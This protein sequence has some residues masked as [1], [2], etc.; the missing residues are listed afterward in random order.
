MCFCGEPILDSCC[1]SVTSETVLSGEVFIFVEY[2]R[3]RCSHIAPPPLAFP[4]LVRG[5]GNE[6]WLYPVDA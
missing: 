1:L 3:V 5:G 2:L 4:Y 6:C